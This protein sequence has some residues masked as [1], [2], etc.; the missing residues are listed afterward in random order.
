[1]TDRAELRV[2]CILL[3][4][5]RNNGLNASISLDIGEVIHYSLTSGKTEWTWQ[6]PEVDRVD[7][8]KKFWT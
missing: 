3:Y 2:F 7:T 4:I 1:M 8:L 5:K 6:V